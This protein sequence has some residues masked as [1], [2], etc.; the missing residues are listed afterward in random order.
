MKKLPPFKYFIILATTMFLICFGQNLFSWELSNIFIELKLTEDEFKRT[1]GFNLDEDFIHLPAIGDKNIFKAAHDLS[2]C[3]NEDVRKF[4]YVYLNK[5]RPYLKRSIEQSYLYLNTIEEILKENPDIPQEISLLPLLE[6]G[7]NPHAVSKSKAVGLWQFMDATSKILG[8]KN[9]KWVDERRDVKKSTRAAI[10]HLRGLYKKFN[11]WELALAAYNGGCNYLSKSLNATN[12]QDL[13]TLRDTGVLYN[14]THEYVPRYIAL[15]LIYKNQKIF[16]IKN[17]I[18][19]PT[20]KKVKT[21]A[22]KKQTNLDKK[23]KKL[24]IPLSTIKS[25]NPEL[26]QD[27]TPP[28]A[29][30]LLHLP[31]VKAVIDIALNYNEFEEDELAALK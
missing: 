10:R 18:T 28:V 26:K 16:V 8:L 14:E 20:P 15:M 19:I 27:I 30:Y 24:K 29:N 21:I 1:M 7:F 2:I 9:D 3:R 13:W 11:S 12:T 22:L 25:L 17:E 4:I 23:K 6:S 5:G 31:D